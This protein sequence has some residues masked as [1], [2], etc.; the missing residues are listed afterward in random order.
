MEHWLVEQAFEGMQR[1]VETGADVRRQ[2]LTGKTAVAE[3]AETILTRLCRIMGGHTLGRRSPFGFWQNDVRA[4]GFL[5]PPWPLAFKTL[6]A[7]LED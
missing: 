7:T 4:L 5:R 3:L 6:E 2:V 1:A